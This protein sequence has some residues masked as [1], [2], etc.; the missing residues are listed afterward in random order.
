MTPD[1][2]LRL[3]WDP[4]APLPT[5]WPAG[6]AG[7][8]LLFLV[9]VGGGIPLGVLMARDGGISPLIT[10]LLYLASDVVIAVFTEPWLA[11]VRWLGRHVPFV[12]RIGERLARLSGGAGLRD[13]GARGPLGLILVSFT[14][15]P[16]MGRAAAGA[17][18][19]G[20]LSGWGLAITGDMLYFV[21]LMASTLWISGVLGDER[22]TIGAVLVATWVLPTLIRHL[23]GSRTKLASRAAPARIAPVL[24]AAPVVTPEPVTRPPTVPRSRRRSARSSRNRLARGQGLHG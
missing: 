15:S 19:H 6:A 14:T 18:G 23:R 13:G 24:A 4:T 11:F 12:G 7:A 22:L 20:F 8:F 2:L 9:P 16:T 3:L 5:T 17:A 10:A 1:E 21:L